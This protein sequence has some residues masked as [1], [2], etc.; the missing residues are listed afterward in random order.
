MPNKKSNANHDPKRK[1][2]AKAAPRPRNPRPAPEPTA[3]RLTRARSRLNNAPPLMA[4]LES[5]RDCQRRALVADPEPLPFKDVVQRLGGT[6][7]MASREKKR[8]T[9]KLNHAA[10]A[11]AAGP[12]NQGQSSGSNTAAASSSSSSSAAPPAAGM[13]KLTPSPSPSISP[14]SSS[15]SGSGRSSPSDQ[16]EYAAPGRRI[17]KIKAHRRAA[18]SEANPPDQNQSASSSSEQTSSPSAAG[19]SS[20][21]RHLSASP[22]SSSELSSPPSSSPSPPVAGPSDQD[23]HSSSSSRSGP[24]SPSSSP[25]AEAQASGSP[26]PLAAGPSNVIPS[27]STGPGSNSDSEISSPNSPT[28]TSPPPNR[29]SPDTIKIDVLIAMGHEQPSSDEYESD[30]DGCSGDPPSDGSEDESSGSGASSGYEASEETSDD[31]EFTGSESSSDSEGD[32]GSD[33]DDAS[34]G[35]CSRP[36]GS[37]GPFDPPGSPGVLIAAG[38]SSDQE[39]PSGYEADDEHNSGQA[40]PQTAPLNGPAADCSTIVRDNTG[41]WAMVSNISGARNRSTWF[42]GFSSPRLDGRSGRPRRPADIKVPFIDYS[43]YDAQIGRGEDDSP[44]CAQ[45]IGPLRSSFPASVQSIGR[46]DTPPAYSGGVVGKRKRSCDD[47]EDA[48]A[49]G[50]KRG[51]SSSPRMVVE[52]S[53]TTIMTT[54]SSAVETQASEP[55]QPVT[56]TSDAPVSDEPSPVSNEPV[57][58]AKMATPV[59]DPSSGEISPLVWPSFDPEIP[60]MHGSGLRARRHY[61]W[62]EQFHSVGY[63]C[64]EVHPCFHN[65][66]RG[67]H[68]CHSEWHK[69]WARFFKAEDLLQEAAADPEKYLRETGLDMREDFMGALL[70]GASWEVL[71][72]HLQPPAGGRVRIHPARLAK[73]RLALAHATVQV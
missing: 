63:E 2:R 55:Q 45:F 36:S 7:N 32:D 40:A 11:S 5:D 22:S 17:I 72:P 44:D 62:Y 60:G 41:A 33:D 42:A 67:C 68:Q 56:L 61:D 10:R 15:S 65:P 25:S 51:R 16:S 38:S 64:Y 70:Q 69:D 21:D 58:Y 19:P 48:S 31:T 47:D 4:S 28:R 66:G 50:I 26:I 37:S 54:R 39:Y 27:S 29:P 13:A 8:I 59:D 23:P 71:A 49:A 18:S 34:G 24:S 3:M 14:S 43:G 52:T 53:T 57:A 9:L 35:P 20:Q 30:G 73:Y 46:L 12:S 1:G 6:A